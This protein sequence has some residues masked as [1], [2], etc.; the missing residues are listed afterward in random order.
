MPFNQFGHS[1]TLTDVLRERLADISTVNQIET[2]KL[3]GRIRNS[4]ANARATPSSNSD[5]VQGDFEGDRDTREITK[6]G[7]YTKWLVKQWM[8]GA[9]VVDVVIHSANA[10][11]SANMMG[12][13]NNYRHVNKLPQNC[14][15]VQ[16]EHTV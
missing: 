11:G 2:G 8:D 14:V 5:V 3:Q 13:I 4:G 10:I 9:P 12:Y 16:I 6:V 1:A 15:R 7:V